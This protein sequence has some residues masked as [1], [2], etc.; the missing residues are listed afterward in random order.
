[1]A[2]K[3]SIAE[4]QDALADVLDGSTERN[5]VATAVRGLLQDFALRYPGNAVEVRV[6]PFGAVQC[7]EG[8]GHTRGTPPNVVE[9]SS[10]AFLA[11]ATGQE[12]WEALRQQG[13]ISASGARSNLAEL[14]PMLAASEIERIQKNH[15]AE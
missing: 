10:E 3:I 15:Q 5:T 2:K 14:F 7:I 9:L 1:M 13:K 4:W 6:P 11:L 8:P 12:G